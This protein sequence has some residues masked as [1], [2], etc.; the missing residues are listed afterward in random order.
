MWGQTIWGPEAKLL[1]AALSAT[2]RLLD[3][4]SEGHL[5]PQKVPEPL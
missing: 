3:G 4:G 2:V 5:K 1:K